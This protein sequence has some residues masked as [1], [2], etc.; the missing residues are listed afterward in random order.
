MQGRHPLGSGANNTAY[1]REAVVNARYSVLDL[2]ELRG[3]AQ[4]RT[5]GDILGKVPVNKANVSLVQNELAL[6]HKGQPSLLMNDTPP[7]VST[8]LTGLAVG[9]KDK[10]QLRE[11]YFCAGRVESDA[12]F[13]G[14]TPASGSIAVQSGGSCSIRYFNYDNQLLSPGD[15]LI[16]DIVDFRN[17]QELAKAT[18]HFSTLDSKV[19][20]RGKIPVIVRKM[21]HSTFMEFPVHCI[22][23]LAANFESFFGA[24]GDLSVPDSKRRSSDPADRYIANVFMGL[25]QASGKKT[26]TDVETFVF[27][28][29][30][31]ICLGPASMARRDMAF[32]GVVDLEAKRTMM[33]F[34]MPFINSHYDVWNDMT[35]RCIGVSLGSAKSGDLVRVNLQI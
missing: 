15:K 26:K 29:F 31:G 8:S 16:W 7:S 32:R 10:Y 35:S 3:Q 22:E 14:P 6:A 2:P 33:N 19:L 12:D 27:Q 34:A 30:S 23:L 17:T 21:D 5:P 20:P 4:S 28:T 1:G 11:L 24:G 25:A 13:T 9:A 18:Q